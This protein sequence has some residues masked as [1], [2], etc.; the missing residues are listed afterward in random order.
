MKFTVDVS[1]ALNLEIKAAAAAAGVTRAEW[2]RAA[3]TAAAHPDYTPSHPVSIPADGP[4]AGADL[5]D[6]AD[7]AAALR[8]A[9]EARDEARRERSAAAAEVVELSARLAHVE[10]VAEE[11]LKRVG[12]AAA[13]IA[14]LTP[15]ADRMPL[16]LSGPG[17]W[18]GIR[19]W[20][21]G[22]RGR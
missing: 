16:Y 14:R 9:L 21:A 6:L 4:A 13:T 5:G 19:S 22:L 20:W 8:S 17:V 2:T 1:D 18:D 15:E 10:G 3:L 11:R 12:D 7:A